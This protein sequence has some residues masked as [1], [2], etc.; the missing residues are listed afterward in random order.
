MGLSYKEVFLFLLMHYGIRL[1]L[2]HL[3]RLVKILGIKKTRDA[4]DLRD[5]IFAINEL[6]LRKSG[7]IAGYRQMTQRMHV[8]HQLVVGR[9]RVRELLKICD[10]KKV[11]QRPKTICQ[12][13][14]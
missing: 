11:V 8:D 9:E 14:S 2:R 10:Q 3:K 13:R 7:D 4:S 5:V 1:S 6:E 12:Q